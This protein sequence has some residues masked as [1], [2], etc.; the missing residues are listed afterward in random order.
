MIL[1]QCVFVFIL[2]KM[3][4]S[5]SLLRVKFSCYRL[6]AKNLTISTSATEKLKENFFKLPR[7]NLEKLKPLHSELFSKVNWGRLAVFLNFADQLGL[8][9]EEWEL[10]FHLVVPT[11]TQIQLQLQLYYIWKCSKRYIRTG[12]QL[13]RLFEAAQA[14]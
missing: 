1:R 11:L 5:V 3:G 9:E 13:A 12:L 8:T 14:T 6:T 2:V 4:L 7:S 10:L